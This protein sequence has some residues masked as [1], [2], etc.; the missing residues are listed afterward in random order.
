MRSKLTTL[1]TVIGAVTVLVLA[2][3]TIALATTGKALL[4]GKI[5]TSSKMTA[6]SR[7]TPGTGLQVRTKSTAN[8]P[9]AVNGKGKVVNLNADK[10]DGFDG[11]TRVLSWTFTGNLTGS[12]V[13]KLAGLAPGKYLISYD[14]YMNGI[15]SAIG[16][17]LRCF[18]KKNVGG[19]FYGGEVQTYET[20]LDFPS[21]TSTALMTQ[22]ANG[23]LSLQCDVPQSTTTWN[24]PLNQPIRIVA[25]PL[26]EVTAKGTPPQVRLGARSAK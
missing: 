6:I 9:F 2:G 13:F 26:A 22:P 5:N 25:T 19:A 18:L 12:K 1:L 14:V 3:N 23:D 15:S 7:T 10:V 24:A 4:A 17:S 20:A 8:A 11:G 16:E 21:F